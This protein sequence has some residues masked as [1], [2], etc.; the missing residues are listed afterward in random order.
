MATRDVVSPVSRP[1]AA[2]EDEKVTP[3]RFPPAEKAS[4]GHRLVVHVGLWIPGSG[5]ALALLLTYRSLSPIQIALM[6]ICSI[7]MYVFAASG[8][9]AGFHRMLTHR[10]FQAVPWLHWT[11]VI[12]GCSALQGPPIRWVAD[13]RKHHAHSDQPDDPHSP[14]G[15]GDGWR[16]ML[17]GLWHAHTGWLLTETKAPAARFAKEWDEDPWMKRLEKKR[18]YLPI[19]LL[20]LIGI[21]ALLGFLIT[22]DIQG[23]WFGIVWIGLVRAFFL[24]QFTFAINSAC[25]VVGRETFDTGDESRD[26]W[27]L[28]LPTGGESN[29]NGHHAFPSSYRHGLGGGLDP[30]AE[31]VR[32]WEKRGWVY[33]V[34]RMK[35]ERV[36]EKLKLPSKINTG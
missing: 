31:L 34:K 32:W 30:T 7:G 15:H 26:V 5:V 27:W 23:V 33:G 6:M 3:T 1:Q 4:R 22:G 8:I 2:P 17:L 11:L 29:H 35:V 36:E 28:R 10:S 18:Y 12:A 13:H 16:G 25:H 14:H 24:L 20:S 9:T 21:P 19:A